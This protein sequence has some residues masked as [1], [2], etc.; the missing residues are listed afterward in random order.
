[1]SEYIDYGAGNVGT[2]FPDG[3]HGFTDSN[4]VFDKDGHVIIP[5]NPVTPAVTDDFQGPPPTNSIFTPLAYHQYD[6]FTQWMD[7]DPMAYRTAANGLQIGYTSTPFVGQGVANNYSFAPRAQSLTLG[8]AA[9]KRSR[10]GRRPSYPSASHPVCARLAAAI[11]W[12]AC[13]LP[14]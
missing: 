4:G 2:E 13:A 3:Q 8:L 14:A 5:N 11:A 1:M 10:Y 12:V 9:A 7:A 6:G